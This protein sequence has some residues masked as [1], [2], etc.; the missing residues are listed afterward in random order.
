MG[1]SQRDM[2]LIARNWLAN[3]LI[4]D[5]TRFLDGRD[6]WSA[7]PFFDE[8]DRLWDLAFDTRASLRR[9]RHRDL[10]A[11]CGYDFPE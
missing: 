6:D 9:A 5:M 11:V 2:A 10:R 1:P 7:P 4:D 8:I 3:D